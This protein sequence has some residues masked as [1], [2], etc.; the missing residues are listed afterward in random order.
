[1]GLDAVFCHGDRLRPAGGLRADL[2]GAGFDAQTLR[3]L[4]AGLIV[5][6]V[7]VFVGVN[8]PALDWSSVAV[9]VLTGVLDA[10]T[11]KG[12]DAK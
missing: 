3:I 2:L 1:V 9:R 10:L 8:L 6:S 4:G 11:K 5:V 7:Y 12:G